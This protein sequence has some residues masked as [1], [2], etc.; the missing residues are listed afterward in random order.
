MLTIWR[1]HHESNNWCINLKSINH[2]YH[3]LLNI[4][5]LDKSHNKMNLKFFCQSL[6]RYTPF[7][8]ALTVVRHRARNCIQCAFYNKGHL[9][10][11]L[12]NSKTL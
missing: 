3:R 5:T 7:N 8:N 10:R 12:K 2:K 4:I 1:S 9:L 6:P 11:R